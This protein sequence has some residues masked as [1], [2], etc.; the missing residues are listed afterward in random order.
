MDPNELPLRDI[1]LPDAVSW[2][3][4]AWGWWILL[5]LLLMSVLFLGWRLYKRNQDPLVYLRQE[6]QS[7]AQEFAVTEDSREL[8]VSLSRMLRLATIRLGHRPQVAAITGNEWLRLLDSFVPDDCVYRFDS[9]VGRGFTDLPYKKTV[10]AD[11]NAMLE[12]VRGWLDS[13]LPAEQ[14]R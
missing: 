3:P 11:G 13:A 9:E 5:L 1:H 2:W 14:N 8:A 6:L 12:L 7:V 10:D 4:L